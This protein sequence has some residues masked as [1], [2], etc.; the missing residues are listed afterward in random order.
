MNKNLKGIAD[1]KKLFLVIIL[2]LPLTA[3]KVEKNQKVYICN[4]KYNKEYHATE[5]CPRLDNCVNDVREIAIDE[6]KEFRKACKTCFKKK[7][8][9]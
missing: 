5:K 8:R 2:L 6:A 3:M 1:M 9:K 7:K 4:D